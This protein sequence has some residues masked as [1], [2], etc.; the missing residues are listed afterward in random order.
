MDLI[1]E[2]IKIF[3]SGLV[4]MGTPYWFIN[5]F[6]RVNQQEG[7]IVIVFAIQ[8]EAKIAIRKRLYIV[9]ISIRVE[10]FYPST[11]SSQYNKYQGFGYN[12]SF[13]KKPPACSLCSNNHTTADHFCLICQAKGKPCQHLVIKYANCKGEHKANSKAYKI[14]QAT[15]KKSF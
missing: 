10:R 5:T 8:K 1:K 6:K 12:E 13:C 11:P 9:G 3:N 2:E 15:I 4:L 14:Y 7:A